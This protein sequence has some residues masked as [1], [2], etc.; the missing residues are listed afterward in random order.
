VLALSTGLSFAV[1]CYERR[2]ETASHASQI[3]RVQSC[4]LQLGD[5]ELANARD[6]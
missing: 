5:K 2:A 6:A 3:L 4:L 1:S